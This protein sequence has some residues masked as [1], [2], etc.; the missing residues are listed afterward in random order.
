MRNT[1]VP[2]GRDPTAAGQSVSTSDQRVGLADGSRQPA[3]KRMRPV[4]VVAG[5]AIAED[6][7]MVEISLSEWCHPGPQAGI[8][9]HEA[10]A[11]RTLRVGVLGGLA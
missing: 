9:A 8:P 5:E 4:S 10:I 11:D 6:D 1:D 3:P 7:F 2:R